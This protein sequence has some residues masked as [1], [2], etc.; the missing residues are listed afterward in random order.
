[1]LRRGLAV[2]VAAAAIAGLVTAFAPLGDDDHGRSGSTRESTFVDRDGDGVLERGSGDPLVSRTALARASPPTRT[3]AR[4]AQLT[5][6]HVTDEESPVRLE[7]LDR[8]GAP[9]TSA[10][11]PQEALTAQVLRAAVVSLNAERPEA[12]VVTGDLVDNAQQNEVA[13]AVAVLNGGRVD[14]GS[15]ARRYEGVQ[16]QSNPDPFY[17]RSDVDPPRHPGLLTRAQRPFVSPGLDAPWYP[18]VG[19]HDLLV[20]GNLA[21]TRRTEAV[22]LGDRKLVRL[23]Q[24]ALSAANVRDVSPRAVGAL[25]AHGLPGK[26]MRVTPDPR[27]RELRPSQMLAALRHGSGRGAGGRWLD[28]SFDIGPKVRVIVLDLISRRAGA[29]GVVHAGQSGW[30]A[31]QLRAARDRW[32][33]VFSHT[34]LSRTRGGER[35]TALLDRDPHVVAAVAGDVHRNTIAARRTRAGGYWTITTSS[36]VDYPQ[37]ARMFELVETK[38]GVAVRTWVVD[39]APDDELAAV[40]RELAFLDYQ[41]GRPSGLA[42]SRADRNATLFR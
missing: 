40:S 7:M 22:A 8:R 19:N 33:V 16:E 31:R 35:L 15:G 4:F 29:A 28:Y 30:L 26:T 9:F 20:Q 24:A 42:G 38:G 1:V 36:L 23:S 6:A 21:P 5:D 25:L 37:Q 12:V 41:G 17:Y 27:R 34:P 14:P 11:R 2:V 32:V 3:L 10:F 39:A 13:E 18:T